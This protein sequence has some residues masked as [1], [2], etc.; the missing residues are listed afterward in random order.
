MTQGAVHSMFN[1]HDAATRS[2]VSSFPRDKGFKLAEFGFLQI[3]PVA[4]TRCTA[5]SFL[6]VGFT[7][8]IE[9]K[10]H[11]IYRRH[12]IA[13]IGLGA[14][15]YGLECQTSLKLQ[16]AGTIAS[17]RFDCLSVLG[18]AAGDSILELVCSGAYRP[19]LIHCADKDS[20]G[21]WAKHRAELTAR[22]YT[23]V[24]ELEGAE[25]FIDSPLFDAPDQR[26]TIASFDVFDTL[27][28]RR[29]IDPWRIFAKVG[30]MTGLEDFL[31]QR[32]AAEGRVINTAY[33]FDDIY[34]ELARHYGWS[35]ERRREVQALELC[36]ELDA[37]IPITENL[38][39]VRDGDL[40]VSDM[41]LSEE[42]IRNLLVK[43]G[44]T[45]NVGLFVESH[46]KSSGRVWPIID[47]Q[48]KISQ[49]LG[50]NTHADVTMPA[51]FGLA[52]S[53]TRASAMNLV[54]RTLMQ[55]GLRDLALLCR[56]SRL[57]V[58]HDNPT[59]RT[60][61]AIQTSCNVPLLI[62]ASV[63]LARRAVALG[64]TSLAFCSRDCN[65]W[66]PL[67]NLIQAKMGLRLETDYFLTSRI[68][69]KKGSD[70]YLDYAR[71][72]MGPGALV[73]D[74]CGTGWTMAN[75]AERLGLSA[76]DLFLID[77][78]PPLDTFERVKQTPKTCIVHKLFEKRPN[79]NN[80][81]LE[82]ANMADH[83]MIVDMRTVGSTFVPVLAPNPL[84]P[85][86]NLAIR[87]QRKSFFAAAD[88]IKHYPLRDVLD[89]DDA[90]LSFLCSSLYEYMSKQADCFQMF[91]KTFLSEND[92]IVQTVTN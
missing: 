49:H 61:Q 36:C 64:S 24:G 14:I 6:S 45:A 76:C 67:F 9:A 85:D 89:L 75:L 86:E 1:A 90:S 77:H 52:T 65:L 40:L 74:L 58:W 10:L 38:S 33:V 68:A 60:L 11:G 20:F 39:R 92:N 78:C 71:Q 51:R 47:A 28:A 5:F 26:P 88:L 18:C 29:C 13:G 19:G 22:R 32:Q 7:G 31:Q 37:V 42:A 80:I 56:E 63:F 87:E 55:A 73:V 8:E 46:G 3:L 43:A 35:D 27:I 2:L 34:D 16:S 66:L 82:L 12:E 72:R 30:E 21:D 57:L 17:S 91:A 84:S 54:E 50:D 81:V 69:R 4:R 23:C 62:L 41:Y 70:A 44:L 25:L 59:V 48:F 15:A 79:A 53:L 83:G